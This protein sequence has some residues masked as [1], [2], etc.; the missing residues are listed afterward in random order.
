MLLVKEQT[1]PEP[2]AAAEVACGVVVSNRP[3]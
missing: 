2:L 3:T 1:S